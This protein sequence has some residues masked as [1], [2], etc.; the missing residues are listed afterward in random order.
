MA[1]ARP[2]SSSSMVHEQNGKNLER[3]WKDAESEAAARSSLLQ[4][5]GG[6]YSEIT[7]QVWGRSRMEGHTTLLAQSDWEA[8]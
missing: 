1:S 8:L 6:E 3:A 5:W 7:V 4:C 2:D